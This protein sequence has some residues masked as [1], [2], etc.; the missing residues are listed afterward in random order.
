MNKDITTPHFAK[1]DAISSVIKETRIV[2]RDKP[3]TPE[4][5]PQDK[6]HDKCI[7]STDQPEVQPEVQP[8]EQPDEP[9]STVIA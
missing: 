6:M 1:E 5:P 9:S 7:S 4:K 2:P 8:D 3:G